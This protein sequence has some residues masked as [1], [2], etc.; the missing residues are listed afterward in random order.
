MI[1]IIIIIMGA[2]P[3]EGSLCFK[4]LDQDHIMRAGLSITGKVKLF[5]FVR[6]IHTPK[7]PLRGIDGL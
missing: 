6:K 1:T 7:M 4:L 3:E 2:C 5:L